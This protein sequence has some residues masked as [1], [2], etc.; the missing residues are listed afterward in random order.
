MLYTFW[1]APK[2]RLRA[3][4]AIDPEGPVAYRSTLPV[5]EIV[6]ALRA[7]GIPAATSRDAGG[8][9]RTRRK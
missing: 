7:D 5:D 1:M 4:A 8:H 2:P 9:S 6:A 3:V